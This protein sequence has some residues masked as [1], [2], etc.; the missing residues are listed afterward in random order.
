MQLRLVEGPRP[1]AAAYRTGRKADAIGRPAAAGRKG[2]AGATKGQ[3][4]GKGQQQGQ[5]RGAK[6]AGTGRPVRGTV[7]SARGRAVHWADWQ[8]DARTRRV[9]RAGVAAAKAALEQAARPEPG[10]PLSKA[11]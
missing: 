1:D 8:L 11:S 6:A 3:G 10:T 7:R 4:K 5:A 2:T 9:G